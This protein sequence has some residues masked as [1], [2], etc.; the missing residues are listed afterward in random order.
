[1]YSTSKHRSSVLNNAQEKSGENHDDKRA[2]RNL[3]DNTEMMTNIACD[4]TKTDV[5]FDDCS[6]SLNIRKGYDEDALGLL[7][8][9][10]PGK[11]STCHIYLSIFHLIK[12]YAKGI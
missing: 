1:M 8:N 11:S 12:K 9:I 7:C 2:I 5:D 4:E 3:L 6:Y 10:Q